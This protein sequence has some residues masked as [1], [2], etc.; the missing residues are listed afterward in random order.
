MAQQVAGEVRSD[1]VRVMP[2]VFVLLWSTGFIGAKFGLPYAEPFTF[3]LLRMLAV[4]ALLG[5]VALVT[6]APW[7][8]S[9]RLAG[10]IAVAGLLV[11]A[12]YLG[13]VF[14][15]I[16]QKVPAG[17]TSLI[18][19]I[20]PLLTAALSGWLLGERVSARQWGGLLLGLVGV[21]LVVSEKITAGTGSAFGLGAAVAA[22]VGITLGTL[23]QKRH[24]TGM[25]LRTGATIQYAA[26]AVA[27]AVIAPLTESMRVQWTGE[28]VF[29]LTW[30][31][32]VLSVGA[33]FLLFALIR[34]GAAAR[35][36]SLFYLTPPVTAVVAW[37]MFDERL[38]AVALAGMAMT[39]VGVAL[40]NRSA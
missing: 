26:T 5:L 10:H 38:G 7:P 32:L 25:D 15:A 22:L 19:G 2:A 1:W 24:C 11:H 29:A 33:I 40:V 13:G 27:F 39:V 28:F 16:S 31:T 34:R 14:F 18:V 12:V 6:R 17:I 30:L 23:Y 21:G 37:A 8:R 20:Q 9:W 3:L 36:A 35:V 4:A